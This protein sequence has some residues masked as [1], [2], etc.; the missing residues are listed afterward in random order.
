MKKQV[1]DPGGPGSPAAR[2]KKQNTVP[3]PEEEEKK[4]KQKEE[5]LRRGM[6]ERRLYDEKVVKAGLLGYIKDPYEQNLRDAIRNR[7]DSYSKSTVKASSGLMHSAREMYRDV[8]HMQTVEVPDE[9]FDTTFIRY[10][11]LGTGEMRRE[12]ERVHALCQKYSFYSFEGTRNKGD[13]CIYEYGAIKYP[14]SLN[15]HLT[16][17]LERFMKRAVFALYPGISRRRIWAIINGITNDRRY[18]DEVEFVDKKASKVSTNEASAIRAVIKE[19]R[20]VLGLANPTDKISE[21]KKDKERY[22]RLVLHYFV[23]LDRELERKAEMKLNGE[24]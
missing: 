5:A 18:E 8:T 7:V 15:K 16:V 17:N 21:L 9:L 14:T 3:S 11:M 1:D 19:H 2:K 13:S 12:N 10:L 24:K 6:Q 20:A 4:K 22:H 23:F